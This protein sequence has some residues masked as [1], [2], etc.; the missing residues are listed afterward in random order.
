[1]EKESEVSVSPLSGMRVVRVRRSVFREPMTVM[2]FEG[3]VALILGDES[4]FE[5]SE[6]ESKEKDKA[7]PRVRIQRLAIVVLGNKF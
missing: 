4:A 5:W 2:V 1:M 3:T 6:E 7:A